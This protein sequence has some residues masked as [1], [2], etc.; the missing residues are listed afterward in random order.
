MIRGAYLT[1]NHADSVVEPHVA[2]IVRDMADRSDDLSSARGIRPSVTLEVRHDHRAIIGLN[3]SLHVH[4][5]RSVASSTWMIGRSERAT[6]S[7]LAATLSK[8]E[9]LFLCGSL[10]AYSHGPAVGVDV[11]EHIERL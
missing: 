6:H 9:M 3:E 5:V 1:R 4:D 8:I 10:I 7:A 2:R 11:A